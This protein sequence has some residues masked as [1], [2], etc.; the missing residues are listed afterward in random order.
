[1]I[2]GTV[3]AVVVLC[4][5]IG[6]YALMSVLGLF[7]QETAPLLLAVIGSYICYLYG[8]YRHRRLGSTAL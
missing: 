8:R 6:F 4:A 7:P 3:E 5:V 2:R 1:M